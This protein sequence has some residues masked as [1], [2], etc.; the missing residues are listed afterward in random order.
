MRYKAFKIAAPCAAVA[1]AATIAW[2][3]VRFRLATD[4][5][6]LVSHPTYPASVLERRGMVDGTVLN[7]T[8]QVY[9]GAT[10]YAQPTVPFMGIFPQSKAD[11][12]GH[13]AITLWLGRYFI[14]AGNK[15]DGYEADGGAFFTRGHTLQEVTL[16]AE[17][18]SATVTVRT[19]PKAG[20]LT[21]TV[22]DAVTGS[23]LNPCTEFRWASELSNFSSGTGI[24]GPK[25]RTLVPPDT[26]LVW[27]VWADGYKPW[28]YPGT[29]HQSAVRSFRLAPGQ[30]KRVTI[31]MQPG[32]RH[33]VAISYGLTAVD[34][35]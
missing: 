33:P 14:S 2:I 6:E 35:T 31:R 22:I 25:Y 9:P 34:G 11:A 10:V 20:I 21:G 12:A 5:A 15:E 30:S 26:D 27:M 24:V 29:T 17:H 7:E 28:Y 13:F 1:I 8:G 23:P 19:G 4:P 18:P 3:A 32:N 16:S